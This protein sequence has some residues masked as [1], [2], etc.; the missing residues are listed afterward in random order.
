[1][2][3]RV[4]VLDTPAGDLQSLSIVFEE[5]CGPEA[6]VTR[7]RS[8]AAMLDALSAHPAHELVVLDYELGDGSTSGAEALRSLR[9]HAPDLP[10]VGV[11]AKGD[12]DLAM[13]V[14]RAGAADFFVRDDRLQDRISTVVTR[15][16]PTLRLLEENRVL[17][18]H[19]EALQREDPVFREL[20]WVSPAMRSVIDT[21]RRVASVPRPVLIQGERGTGKELV[22]RALH[23]A[24]H[25]SPRPFVVVNCAAFPEALL[26]S[27]LFGHERGAFT[28]ADQASPGRF[29]QAKGG[30]LFLDE[31]GNMGLGFQRKIL[32]VVEYGTFTPV[33]GR[34]EL[35]SDAR[36]VAATN[37]D[38]VEKIREGLFLADL[39]DRLAFEVIHLPPLRDRPEDVVVLAEHFMR[40][41][42]QEVPAFRGKRLSQ[43]AISQLEAYPFAGNIRELKTIIERAVYRDTT[44][45]LT[46]VDL[47]LST[48]AS[49]PALRGGFKEQVAQFQQRLLAEAL[50]K[51]GGNQAAAARRLDLTYH[52]FRY[53]LGKVKRS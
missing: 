34:R 43:E 41:F 31:L 40:H 6:V 22:A 20:I 44:N 12:L 23:D 11:A 5:V 42:G 8:C 14:V 24:A 52:Q 15:L 36:I 4:L 29:E 32:R 3:S 45:E 53:H 28:G 2:L 48:H 37:A 18:R 7:V 49:L 1:M 16:A 33:G 13:Q 38:L 10:V 39:Y 35:H 47:G 9:E 30:T 17:S 27:E 50:R 46:S 19:T 21:I 26:E 51:E 25:P